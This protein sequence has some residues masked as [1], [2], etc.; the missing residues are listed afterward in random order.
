MAVKQ[1]RKPNEEAENPGQEK[2]DVLIGEQVILTLGRPAD[3]QRV[4][5]RHLWE[6]C[7]RVNV[8]VGE[9]IATGRVANSYFVQ[10]TK[11]GRI[12]ES[13]PTIT[14]QY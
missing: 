14:K 4:Q 12:L 2:L 13:N 8:F 10:A 5:V 3:L 6:A 7:Y 9:N 11:E 1:E